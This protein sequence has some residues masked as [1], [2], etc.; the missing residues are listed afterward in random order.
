LEYAADYSRG[1]ITKPGPLTLGN[2]SAVV[3]AR[4]EAGPGGGSRC[5]RGIMDEINVFNKALTLAEIQTQQKAPAYQ[6]VTVEPVTIQQDPQ[7]LTIFS[8]QPATFQVNASGTPPLGYQW[9]R[10]HA[11]LEAVVAGATNR[12]YG[13]ANAAMADSGDQ[14]WVEVTNSKNTVTSQRANLIVLAENNHKVSLSFSEGSGTNTANLGNLGGA[15]TLV[16]ANNFPVFSTLT[17][18]GLFAPSSNKTSIDFGTVAD[19][20]GGRAIDLTTSVAPTLGAMQAFTLTGWLNC[21]DLQYGPGG[22]RIFYCQASLGSGGFDLVQQAD[23]VLWMGVNT[24]PDAQP[25]STA[26]SSPRLTS[27]P[28]AG[29]ENWVFFAVTYDGTLTTAN[30]SFFFGSPSQAATLDITVDYDKGPINSIGQLTAGNFSSVDSGARNA[31]GPGSSRCF[32]GLMDELNVFNKVLALAEIQAV[33]K[34]P[35][36]LPVV[37]APKLSAA[38]QGNGI[39][40]T[41]ESTGIFQLQAR[42]NLNQGTWTDETTPPVVNGNQKTVTV[43]ATGAGQFYRLVSR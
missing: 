4:T 29:N 24:W 23:G 32:R 39:V 20:E 3:G 25:F 13:L 22:N 26:L 19:G 8:S 11:G 9:W 43:P 5:F 15:A 31:T 7:S 17:P 27:D 10:K 6:P 30:T 40:I 34:A 16:Q 12:D 28:A 18:A 21:R 37:A 41:W 1:A 38:R 35:A 33:Q 2:F 14:F 42:A 36:G